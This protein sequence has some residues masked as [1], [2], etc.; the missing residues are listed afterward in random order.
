MAPG[1]SIRRARPEDTGALGKMIA[2]FRAE[3]A[4]LRGR[5]GRPDIDAARE[6]FSSFLEKGY[7]VFVAETGGRLAGYLVCRVEGDVIW[8]EQLYVCPG[9]RRRGIGSALYAEAERL[10]EEIDGKTVYNWVHPD[11]NAIISFLKKRGYTV[12]NLIELRR[13]LPGE[14]LAGEVRVGDQRF[15]Y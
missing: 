7:P 12:L 5:E 11:N 13:P 2:A 1:L 15:D 4:R 14:S 10:C 9:F 3:L 6:E 8:A